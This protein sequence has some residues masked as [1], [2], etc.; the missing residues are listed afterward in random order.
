MNDRKYISS[1]DHTFY[2]FPVPGFYT[3]DS[4]AQAGDYVVLS[5]WLSMD[6]YVQKGIREVRLPPELK[7]KHGR[8]TVYV[9]THGVENL[10]WTMSCDINDPEVWKYLAQL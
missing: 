7:E 3:W 5:V 6:S 1:R 10:R 2:K 4:I 9:Q 8:D